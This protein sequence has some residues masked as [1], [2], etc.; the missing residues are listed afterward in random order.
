M[1]TLF[2][3]SSKWGGKHA[4]GYAGKIIVR[5]M[6]IDRQGYADNGQYFGVGA[7]VFEVMDDETG[8]GLVQFSLRGGDV[9]SVRK[10]LSE[11]YPGALRKARR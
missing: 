8:G 3:I 5:R 11:A 7:P 1:A 4:D 10:Y 9:A 6:R 2:Q